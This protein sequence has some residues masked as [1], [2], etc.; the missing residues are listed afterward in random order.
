MFWTSV[1]R[2]RSVWKGPNVVDF[3][4]NVQQCIKGNVP[5]KTAVRSAT[6]L[7]RMVG[8]QF[9]V[10]N[11]KSYANVKITEDMIGHKLG[12]FAPTRKAFHYRQTKNR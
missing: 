10:H 7:P 4:V 11:G 12:E 1:A 5:I 2:A 9:M 6:I 8:A 3:G